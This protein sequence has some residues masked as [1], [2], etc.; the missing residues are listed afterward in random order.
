MKKLYLIPLFLFTLFFSLNKVH[1]DT[2][3]LDVD[4]DVSG[5]IVSGY[6]Y[7][8][9]VSLYN[10]NADIITDMFENQYNTWLSTYSN[11][12]PYYYTKI[13]WY[14]T[15]NFELSFYG[16]T[17]LPSI[18]YDNIYL[19]PYNLVS[20]ARYNGS[21]INYTSF[22]VHTSSNTFYYYSSNEGYIY[23]NRYFYSNFDLR[24]AGFPSSITSIG[25]ETSPSSYN[26]QWLS[27][28]NSPVTSLYDFF[29]LSFLNEYSPV[30]YT[31]VN[32]NNYAYVI[33][34]LKDYTNLIS[35][36]EFYV[37][38]Q[39]CLT[40]VYDYGQREK[41]VTDRCSVVYSDFTPVR[42]YISSS[43]LQNGIVFYLSGYD[44]SI[45]NIVKIDTN[46]FNIS[47]VTS[48]NA[49]EP[50]VIID[51]RPYSAIPYQNLTSSALIN[52]ENDYIPGLSCAL[53][54]YNCYYEQ[55]EIEFSDIFTHPLEVL[56]NVWSSI[57]SIFVLIS[58]F[59]SL[60]PTT[61][62]AFLFSAFMLAI[63]LGLIKIILGQEVNYV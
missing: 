63:V 33:V 2:S 32:L 4:Y 17:S 10:S 54:D 8:Q 18:T 51:G 14:S 29:Q 1:A 13:Y 22:D 41:Q 35:P 5:G 37:K 46:V 59:I 21:S 44:T 61:L 15:T 34:S 58:A 45:D 48:E 11:T 7:S 9:M 47:Y 25:Y 49:S 28:I 40:P 55:Q 53:G 16:L 3:M 24:F 19:L 56:Q 12:Y 36:V 42:A 52:E 38:G 39:L 6:S 31:E 57:S 60:L 23:I 43:E 26:R 50:V 20:N 30:S 27:D 62:Q